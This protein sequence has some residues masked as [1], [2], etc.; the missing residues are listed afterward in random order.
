MAISHILADCFSHHAGSQRR[1]FN[2]FLGYAKV[3]LVIGKFIGLERV[4]AKVMKKIIGHRLKLMEPAYMK[5]IPDGQANKNRLRKGKCEQSNVE[6]SG[7]K[8]RTGCL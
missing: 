8:W 3:F 4:V 7:G 1:N 2:F 5:N 6:K